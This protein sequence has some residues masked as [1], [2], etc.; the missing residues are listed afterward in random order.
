MNFP[1]F[2]RVRRADF[3][4]AEGVA[5]LNHGSFGAT[6][7]V[8]LEAAQAS[9]LQ[10]EADGTAFFRDALPG[11]IRGAIGRVAGFLGGRTE[12]WAFVENATQGLNAIIASLRLEPGDELLCLSQTYG[13]ITNTLRYHAERAGAEVVS[14]PVPVPFTDPE[15]LLAAIAA[16]IAPRTRLGLFDHITSAG[17]AVLPVREMA[18]LCRGRGV[19]V[20]IDGAHAPGQ[21][22]LDVPALGVDWYV[23]NLHKWAFAAKGTAV[24]WCA[25]ER[26]AALHPVA[27][28]HYLGQGFTAEFDYSGTR[29]NSAWLA[30]P[31]ALDYLATLD[32]QAVRAHNNALAREAGEV[33]CDA[34]GSEIAAAPAYGAAMASVRLPGT[35]GADR[36]LAREVAR[37]LTERHGITVNVMALDDSLW[38]RVSAQIYNEIDEYRPLAEIAP[39]V[40]REIGV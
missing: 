26:Q 2:G 40:L 8:V 9:R 13:A 34:W 24:L 27:I 19:A 11:L 4:L 25:P 16:A 10:M 33:L 17:A 35:K 22:L 37:R 29:D 15:P 32:P 1:Q 7:R 5:H 3:H 31:A 28:S 30:A 20:A 36:A 12:D 6:P 21:L 18:A 14:V 38:V 23:G 39:R